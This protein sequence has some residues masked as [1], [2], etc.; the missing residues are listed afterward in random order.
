MKYYNSYK[1]FLN[2]KVEN[3]S[4]ELINEATE[5]PAQT[6]SKIDFFKPKEG[7]DKDKFRIVNP[8]SGK[9]VEAAT[10]LQTIKHV[11]TIA[12]N[13][14]AT[15]EDKALLKSYENK[16]KEVA[17]AKEAISKFLGSQAH[18]KDKPSNSSKPTSKPIG[19]DVLNNPNIKPTNKPLYS[20]LKSNIDIISNPN[21]SDNDKTKAVDDLINNDII[22]ANSEG[23][24][25]NKIYINYKA[26]GLDKSHE[27]ILSGG[28][29]INPKSNHIVNTIINTADASGSEISGRRGV[30]KKTHTPGKIAERAAK[31]LGPPAEATKEIA[32]VKKS[33]SVKIGDTEYKSVKVPDEAGKKKIMA[34][35]KERGIKDPEAEYQLYLKSIKKQNDFIANADKYFGDKNPPVISWY[36]VGKKPAKLISQKDDEGKKKMKEAILFELSD[37]LKAADK[38]SADKLL[39]LSKDSSKLSKE[40]FDKQLEETFAALIDSKETRVGVPDMAELVTALQKLNDGYEVYIPSASNFKLGDVIAIKNVDSITS[41]SSAADISKSSQ[42]IYSSLDLASVKYELGGASS[43]GGKIENTTYKDAAAGKALADIL[44]MYYKIWKDPKATSASI[45]NVKSQINSYITKFK[46][47]DKAIKTESKKK[48]DA[49][50][51]TSTKSWTEQKLDSKTQSLLK[52][53]WEV[54]CLAGVVM[55]KTYNKYTDIQNYGNI[56]YKP[57]TKAGKTGSIETSETNGVTSLCRLQFD[58]SQ[59]SKLGTPNNTFPTR[60][61]NMPRELF[62]KLR[63]VDRDSE[64]KSEKSKTKKVNASKFTSYSQF[65]NEQNSTSQS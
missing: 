52:I 43:S 27:K 9:K 64:G 55:E 40:E 24:G 62:D 23:G 53:K 45:N 41:K 22:R 37:S 65:L 12:N 49:A 59:V 31:R 19:H 5:K 2:E 21:S 42:A 47:N 30:G 8:V 48:S 20:K 63:L 26:L 32:I 29:A 33:G 35:Y 36:E 38:A 4:S 57:K 1:D 50:I 10:F 61:H 34:S 3:D 39:K 17:K 13:K 15:S 7:N 44:S 16:S 54:Y 51:K 46:L 56:S 60:M 58:H 28:K 18:D 6:I 25:A 14:K 11:K